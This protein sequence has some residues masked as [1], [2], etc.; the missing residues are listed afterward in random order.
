[1]SESPKLPHSPTMI[2]F[3]IRSHRGDDGLD[4]VCL[5]FLLGSGVGTAVMK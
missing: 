1:M 5:G 2:V 3:A 4:E